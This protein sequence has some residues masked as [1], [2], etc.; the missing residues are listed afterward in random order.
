MDIVA[1]TIPSSPA[2]LEFSHQTWSEIVNIYFS[3]ALFIFPHCNN[4]D[5][6]SKRFCEIQARI[7]SLR[8]G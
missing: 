4:S 5:D 7:F 1:V 2:E 8:R 6:L 3:V